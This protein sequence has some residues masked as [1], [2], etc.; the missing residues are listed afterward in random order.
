MEKGGKAEQ[1]RAGFDYEL[2]SRSDALIVRFAQCAQ[3]LSHFWGSRVEKSHLPV[4][5]AASAETGAE[6]SSPLEC[7]RKPNVPLHNAN[8]RLS[9][10]QMCGLKTWKWHFRDLFFFAT[11]RTE[12]GAW[13]QPLLSFEKKLQLCNTASLSH[14]QLRLMFRCQPVQQPA[15]IRVTPTHCA[16]A[17]ECRRPLSHKKKSFQKYATIV[18]H[19]GLIETEFWKGGSVSIHGNVSDSPHASRAM[20]ETK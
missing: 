12:E 16:L 7:L 10:K 13:Q 3:E 4:Q 6:Q 11:A 17:L 8:Q 5:H 19:K 20:A 14:T 2:D 9:G 1:R 15:H 18:M